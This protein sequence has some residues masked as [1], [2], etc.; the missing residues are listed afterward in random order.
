[1]C[2]VLQQ[3]DLLRMEH[4]LLNELEWRSQAPTTYTFI[5]M[6]SQAMQTLPWDVFNLAAYFGVR[7]LALLRLA[8]VTFIA[9]LAC[10]L[11][12]SCQLPCCCHA[13]PDT[14]C[15]DGVVA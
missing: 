13:G 11:S 6:F 10:C 3:K 9:A 5:S 14:N 1:V 15:W 8:V 12:I 7:L 2:C 4:V